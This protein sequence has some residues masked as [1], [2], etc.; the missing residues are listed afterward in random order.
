[1]TALE[2]LVTANGAVFWTAT[3]GAGPPVVLCHGG[4]GIYDYL[5]PVAAMVDDLATVYRYDQRGCGRSDDRRPYDV[6]TFVD[7]LDALRAHWGYD[8][9]TVAG[10]S[11]G[12]TLALLYTARYPARTE[13]LAYISGTGIDPAWHDEY[14]SARE[15][16]LPPAERDRLRRLEEQR[17]VATGAE[18]DRINAER[19]TLLE[20]TEY[21][22]ATRFEELP[23]YDRFPVNYALN[24]ALN[25]EMNGLE[26]RGALP[27]QMARIAAPTLVLD[28]EAD[29]RPRWARAQVAELI[30]NA[31]HLT[32]E[33]AG[34]EPWVEQPEA[35]AR[36]LRQFL[37]D[38]A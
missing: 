19:T 8:V 25:A 31:R 24:A 35:T 23:R 18:L 14:R 32:I 6:A 21:Y 13:R 10:H 11:W 15:A 34:H 3:Q 17:T 30:P 5:E 4:P 7:D 27:T 37:V 38:T 2:E 9:W 22:D 36:A 16:K 28:G 33:R 1:M 29:P 12:A 26:D 20:A